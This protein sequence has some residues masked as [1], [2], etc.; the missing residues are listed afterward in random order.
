VNVAEQSVSSGLTSVLVATMPLWVTLLA[1][2]SGGR[3]TPRELAGVLLGLVGVVVLNIGGELR[4]TPGGAVCALLAPMGWALGS[5]ASQRLP[6]PQGMVR[7]ATQMLAGG[8]AMALVSVALHEHVAG[9]PS[10]RSVAALAYLCA[11]G[12]LLGFSAYSHL[13]ANTRPAVAASY[14]YVNPVIAVVLGVLLAGER[15][16]FTSILGTAIVLTAVIVV[17]AARSRQ[18]QSRES[19]SRSSSIVAV[20][21]CSASNLSTTSES[22]TTT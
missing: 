22:P 1:R 19:A 11:F 4:G 13:L 7:T 20:A 8:A 2:L 12:S 14:A 6:L 16:G 9:V 15:F 21:S 5:V 17:L 3:P 10:G 18:S